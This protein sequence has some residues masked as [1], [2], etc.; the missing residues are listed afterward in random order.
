M[1]NLYES[2]YMICG[3]YAGSPACSTSMATT[4]DSM[5]LQLPNSYYHRGPSN[6]CSP[7]PSE[8]HSLTWSNI[9][10]PTL[11]RPHVG[12]SG[13]PYI[14]YRLDTFYASIPPVRSEPSSSSILP[15]SDYPSPSGFEGTMYPFV[16]R[17]PSTLPSRGQRL[18]ASVHESKVLAAH[19]LP[20]DEPIKFIAI[21]QVQGIC[22]QV[23]ADSSLE[24]FCS[25]GPVLGAPVSPLFTSY[26]DW[27]A[28]TPSSQDESEPSPS[29]HGL[30]S[31]ANHQTEYPEFGFNG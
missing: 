30:S 12:E 3:S 5:T 1:K 20:Q 25:G 11:S 31:L 28:Y 21:D 29:S 23:L 2:P 17:I 8:I 7:Y 27:D 18:G 26:I 10:L 6:F 24:N 16:D 22:E 14:P 15:P 4:P 9:D 13:G 19:S